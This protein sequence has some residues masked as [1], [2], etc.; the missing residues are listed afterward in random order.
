MNTQQFAVTP[1]Q[2]TALVAKAQAAGVTITGNSGTVS[3]DGFTVEYAYDGTTL[4]LTVVD[5]PP[6]MTGWAVKQIKTRMD[7][8]LANATI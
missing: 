4:S 2:F 8:E 7:E 5:A 1:A 3:K 6:F